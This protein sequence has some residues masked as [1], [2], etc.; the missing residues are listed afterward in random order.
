MTS[1]TE[2]PV[3]FPINQDEQAVQAKADYLLA[4]DVFEKIADLLDRGLKKIA[5]LESLDD[6]DQHRAHEAILLQGARGSG[7]SAV[8]VNLA[9]YLKERR[10][11]IADRLLIIKPIDPTLLEN[12]K[13]MFLDVFIAALV[14]DRHIKAKLDL[15][16]REAEAFYDQ[17]SKVGSALESAQTQ[18]KQYGIN[19]VRALISG[20][21]IAE[22]AHKLFQRA[23]KLT[24]K[25]LIVLPI[26]D[27]DTALQHAYEKIE[28]V[29]KY[30]VSPCVIPLISGDLALY[31]DVIWRDFHGRL[32]TNSEA[33][34]SEAL[35]RAKRLSI[36]YQRKILPLPRR[37]IVPSLDTYLNDPQV[38]LLDKAT[39]LISFPMFKYWLEAVLNERVNGI[40][41]SYLPLPINTVREFAQ[42]V[43]HVQELIPVLHVKLLELGVSARLDIR[44]FSFMKPAIAKEVAIFAKAYNDVLALETRAQRSKARSQ[45]YAALMARVE[46]IP[47]DASTGLN[48]I[49][50]T[51]QVVIKDYF[52]HHQKGGSVY[53]ILRANEHFRH[54]ATNKSIEY[55][56]IFDTDLFRP[57]QHSQYIQFH[58]T[59][60]IKQEW[61]THLEKYIPSA[62][63]RN[64]P[65]RCILP[66]P[67]PEI[68]RKI[69][70]TENA[71][72]G[73]ELLEINNEGVPNYHDEDAEII[74]RL[75]THYNFYTPL[76]R[77]TLTLTGRIFELLITSLIRNVNEAEILNLMYRP[78]FYSAAGL[79]R[80]KTVDLSSYD[81][82]PND[83]DSNDE[84][85]V[86]GDTLTKLVK[87]INGWRTK[88]GLD[89]T[90]PPHA[91]LI[92][93]VFNKY[94]NQA[95]YFNNPE[96]RHTG[97]IDLFG[98]AL[99]SFNAIWAIFGSFEKGPI[100]GF[101]EIIA[102]TN[103]TEAGDAFRKSTLYKQNIEP[104][105]R[106][107]ATNS[108]EG[109]S[110]NF[111]FRTGAYTYL[112]AS[113]PLKYLFQRVYSAMKNQSKYAE[114][115]ASLQVHDKT[116]SKIGESGNMT[117][118]SKLARPE[119]IRKINGILNLAFSNFLKNK[120]D[121][122]EK[123]LP[124]L[125]ECLAQL[126]QALEAAKLDIHHVSQLAR[127]PEYKTGNSGMSKLHHILVRMARLNR[128]SPDKA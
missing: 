46:K 30:L 118:A 10:A 71:F 42:L 29:R 61:G 70:G 67:R 127:L 91:Q 28:I 86:V 53:L 17:L 123:T 25:E 81:E 79:V 54:L 101:D 72:T 103:I 52:K 8:L 102:Y 1:Q 36:D 26:D 21:G 4:Q 124:E 60:D 50:A 41:N 32:L 3:L 27:V 107:T 11:D 74:R 87:K 44:R 39:E 108:D 98:T 43:S 119:N 24:C 2:R 14:R 84:G 106:K 18:K 94:F 95:N 56:S 9:L 5:R 40:E 114:D 13:D 64:I 89:K 63:K 20:N 75:M 80:T 48:N 34:G 83:D 47:E 122:Q 51:W 92:Y 96:K 69:S 125:S 73:K 76:G 33:E 105:L 38:K 128:Q 49:I 23:L 115:E 109:T 57:Q 58:Q 90:D 100:F 110:A 85:H 15:G 78:P 35:A 66:Y 97:R 16:G 88:N 82:P 120:A 117:P 22:E 112:L 116:N 12:G 93:N 37:I 6:L 126:K 77:T 31:N 68:G 19:R 55:T 62:W 121:I 104:F 59:Y 45:A 113:H 99:Q 7:K 65:E 111:N